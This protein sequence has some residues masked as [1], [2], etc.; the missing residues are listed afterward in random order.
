MLLLSGKQ[1][2]A[3]W[4]DLAGQPSRRGLRKRLH[5]D[6]WQLQPLRQI[7]GDEVHTHWSGHRGQDIRVPAGEVEGHQTGHVCAVQAWSAWSSLCH[8]SDCLV[9]FPFRG[10]KNFHIFYYIYAGLYHQNKLK[11]YRLPDRTPPRLAQQFDMFY[12]HLSLPIMEMNIDHNVHLAG[13]LTVSTAEWCRTSSPANCTRSSL[14]QFRSASEISASLKRSFNTRPNIIWVFVHRSNAMILCLFFSVCR[15]SGLCT[16]FS[17]PFWTQA[18]L[19]L[20]PSHPNT[21]LIR[22]KCLTRRP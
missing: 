5:S 20:L 8:I 12:S 19:N 2:D 1:S 22:V 13:I 3:A 18:I 10:E 4:E 9:H 16:E 21:R 17:Q 7:P 11:T 15:R 14:T 6:Q